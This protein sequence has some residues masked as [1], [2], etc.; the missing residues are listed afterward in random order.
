MRL[1]NSSLTL[2]A[3][4]KKI[5][6][7]DL[8][9]IFFEDINHSADGGLYAEM[10][11]NRSFE[12][13]KADNQK[14]H[15]TYAWEMGNSK[16]FFIND[17]GPL[18]IKNLHY[19]E[20]KTSG[21]N[22]LANIGYNNG[23]FFEKSKAY[24]FSFFS[25]ILSGTTKVSVSLVDKKG[26]QISALKSIKIEGQ[27][28]I[29]YKAV[30]KAFKTITEGKIVIYFTSQTHLLLDMVSLFPQDTFN[31]RKNY[32][33]KDLGQYLKSLHP[34]F[35]RFPGGCLVHDGT[36]NPDDRNSMYRW[37][38]TLG[39]IEQ[40]PARVNRWG[41][42]QTLGL[43]FYEYFQLCEDISATPMP[44]LPAGVDPHH[45]KSGGIGLINRVGKTSFDN[46][47][48]STYT[49]KTAIGP[50][51]QNPLL[52]NVA[53]PD[54][55]FHNGTYYLYSTTPGEEVGGIRAYTSTDLTHWTSKGRVMK[56]GK[57]NWGKKGFWAPD[58]IERNGKF[59]MYYVANEHLAVLVSKSPLGPFKQEKFGPMHH[60]KEIDAHAFRDDDGQYYIY[61]VRFHNGNE[62]YGAKLNDDMRTI[63]ESSLTKLLV[64]SQSWEKGMA[65]INEGPYMLKK[66][67]T[68]Y[69][70]YS[71][72]HFESPMY[73]SGYATS[74]NPLGPYHKYK[75]NPILQTN[76]I[77]HGTGHHGITTSPDGKEMFMVYHQHYD[78]HKA[79]PRKFDIDRLR[80][81]KDED[82]KTVL[83]AHGP[84]VNRQ[85]IPSGAVDASNFIEAKKPS[86]KPVVIPQNTLL[87]ASQLPDTV[88]IKTSKSQPNRPKQDPTAFIHWHL[89]EYNPHKTG[90]QTIH[91]SL[92]LP[93]GVQNLGRQNL[94]VEIQVKT[95]K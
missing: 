29:K 23:M 79:N 15:S 26:N 40:R 59:Y 76:A 58:L 90:R 95:S 14:Y 56:K 37:K 21:K 94:E 22:S 34:K 9:G 60:T 52:P 75:N 62:I 36:L 2:Y 81:T 83:E 31:H 4:K 11:Q 48:V 17:K 10:I 66:D 44:V 53:D 55:S 35:L 33:R 85:P 82:G 72:S 84:T 78:L 5:P 63:D 80:F 57:S 43:G 65:N 28:W 69:L 61:F 25:K 41:Y 47:L 86:K 46:V 20:V 24:D 54:V 1:P 3:D 19:L 67:G 88:S 6:L 32:I 64:P 71:G 92:I 74:K 7:D 8:Y 73:G 27:Q 70:T 16:S 68:Y 89:W 18:N 49:D 77:V 39:P 93:R 51:Y 30:L 42:N 13:T 87:K 50:T 12:F 38:N 91:G 45:F